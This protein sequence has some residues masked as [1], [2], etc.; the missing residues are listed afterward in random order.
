L[1]TINGLSVV[2]P[3]YNEA[4]N[5]APLALEIA[6][7]L[8]G[9]TPYQILFVDDASTDNTFS[10]LK[11]TRTQ[12]SAL[13][14]LRHTKNAG[15]SAAIVTGI[16]HAQYEWI[17]TLDGD[18]QNN[19]ADLP[20]MITKINEQITLGQHNVFCI[21]QRAKRQDNFIRKLSSRVANAVRRIFLR[22]HCPDS[23]CGIKIFNRDTF[24]RLPLFKNSHRFLP[25]L[26]KRAQATIINV[27]VSHRER[28]AGRSKYGIYN[29]LWVGII[30]LIGV[31][32]LM[33]RP[34][35]VENDHDI[36]AP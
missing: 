5:V 12:C 20:A 13:T 11:Q 7:S 23:G 9:V 32:W 3:V 16:R 36:H 26:F 10:E 18:R 24:L 4:E 31:A 6:N 8:T 30:D 35:D 28:S 21:G 34:I 14:I 22:D 17:A 19:P 25:A 29:R 15:Q 33:R 1:N 2:V 27:P